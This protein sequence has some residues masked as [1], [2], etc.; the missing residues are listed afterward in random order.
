MSVFGDR[1]R[2]RRN[3]MRLSQEDLGDY[4]GSSQRQVSRYE[5]GVNSPTGD[6]IVRMAEVLDTTTDWLLGL[7]DVS[8]RP[9]MHVERLSELELEMLA[10]LRQKSP[11]DQKK[12]VEVV[13]IL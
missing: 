12:I 5:S 6:V 8:G 10:L 3:Q 1:V 2:Q 9:V 4:I 13:K 11:E 7:T